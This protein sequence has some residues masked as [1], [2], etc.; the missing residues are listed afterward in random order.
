MENKIKSLMNQLTQD[1]TEF[2]LEDIDIQ[3]DSKTLNRIKDLVY[4]KGHVGVV[5]K[6]FPVRKMLI[7]A[8]TLSTLILCMGLTYYYK[9]G[10]LFKIYFEKE[11]KISLIENELKLLDK[12]GEL[13]NA[14]YS[15]SGFTTTVRGLINDNDYAYLL[16]DISKDDGSSITEEYIFTSYLRLKD[17]KNN[18]PI[19]C[20]RIFPELLPRTDKNSNTLSYMITFQPIMLSGE[21][22]NLPKDFNIIGKDVVFQIVEL[23]EYSK[24]TGIGDVVASDL[25]NVDFKFN[26][27]GT[28][29][30]YNVN[31]IISTTEMDLEIK[32]IHLSVLSLNINAVAVIKE[33]YFAPKLNIKIIQNDGTVIDK[34]L[35]ENMSSLTS[36]EKIELKSQN[37][38]TKPIDIKTIKS[39]SVNGN[40]LKLN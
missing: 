34:F 26:Y 10:E 22:N 19:I 17:E 33:D 2:L 21:G 9:V 8:A 25:W 40:E 27:T 12:T 35:E 15:T 24:E 23:T 28:P 11:T 31:Q 13:I 20:G 14:K 7:I 6:K 29:I 37:T 5:K 18:N 30:S 4:K 38:F 39:I 16:L 32:D 36:P 1:E 3:I